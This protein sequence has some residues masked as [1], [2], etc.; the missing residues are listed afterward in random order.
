[1]P[2]GEKSFA[3]KQENISTLEESRKKYE[4]SA[5]ERAQKRNTLLQKIFDGKFGTD[6]ATKKMDVIEE[7]AYKQNEKFDDKESETIY[8]AFEE[9]FEEKPD[10]AQLNATEELE[11]INKEKSENNQKNRMEKFNILMKYLHLYK[12][13]ENKL[14]NLE[15]AIK[16]IDEKELQNLDKI[17]IPA[18]PHHELL[19]SLKGLMSMEDEGTKYLRN[20][21]DSWL[22]LLSDAEANKAI[23]E[24]E[25]KKKEIF[26]KLSEK[27]VDFLEEYVNLS[28]TIKKCEQ[29]MNEQT[30][31]LEESLK[32]K[33][34]ESFVQ[35][36]LNQAIKDEKIRIAYSYAN[37]GVFDEE[38]FKK[39][40]EFNVRRKLN[41]FGDNLEMQITSLSMDIDAA[42]S[43]MKQ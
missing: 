17:D 12:A 34:K 21:Q 30:E 29:E 37:S 33:I 22:F 18:L 11:A 20:P 7:D 40:V 27:K 4:K 19:K 42:Q 24:A 14:Q 15:Q 10:I 28:E 2:I 5:K 25:N 26:Q 38:K 6:P 13:I 43:S 1:M 23:N 31:T 8:E 39:I 9:Y 36:V 35:K 41:H 16:I 32:E 3:M